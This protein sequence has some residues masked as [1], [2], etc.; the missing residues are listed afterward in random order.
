MLKFSII[1]AIYNVEE[2]FPKCIESLLEA[3]LDGC[4][5]LLINDGSTDSSSDLC[6]FYAENSPN[7]SVFHKKNGG[8]SDARNFGLLKAKGEF[9][10]F[11]D[12]DDCV[13]SDVFTH[14]LKESS[15]LA[16]S[17]D[18]IFNDYILNNLKTNTL[19]T[20]HQITENSSLETVLKSKGVVWNVWRYAYRKSFLA[21]NNFTFKFG[22]LAEDLEFISRIF[23]LENLRIKFLHLPYYLYSY[24]RDGSIMETVSLRF[25]ECMTNSVREICSVL[26]KRKD[27]ISKLLKRKLLEDYIKQVSKYYQFKPEERKKLRY[28][29]RVKGS[30]L[31]FNATLLAG[32]L[33]ILRRIYHFGR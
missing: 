14:F 22:W 2:Y 31:P 3:D 29:Y 19:T 1:I 15:N 7:V 8:L 33:Y 24:K 23:M 10:I 25:M 9:I 32:F 30:P 27:I 11:I 12:G 18:V 16:D 21:E 13:K 4:E 28:F 20:S 6:D 17:S 26:K 5:V